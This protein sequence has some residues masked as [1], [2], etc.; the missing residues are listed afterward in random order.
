MNNQNA[1]V[2]TILGLTSLAILAACSSVTQANKDSVA[3]AETAVAQTQQAIGNSESGAMQLQSARNSHDQAKQAIK[4]GEGERAARL[5]QEATLNAELATAKSRTA[6]A[7]KAA[8]EVEASI[9]TLRQEAE[10][11]V[12]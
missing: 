6:S 12:R 11:P 9:Q 3:R 10:R 2:C 4:E 5:A 8:N 7:Q 1:R